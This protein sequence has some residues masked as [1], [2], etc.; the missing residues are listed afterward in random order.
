MDSKPRIMLS[1][2]TWKKF[3]TPASILIPSMLAGILFLGDGCMASR[4]GDYQPPRMGAEYRFEDGLRKEKHP[5][6]LFSKKE[7][8]EMAKMGL[9]VG[10]SNEAV[11]SYTPPSATTK[12][13]DIKP[14]SI[15]ARDTVYKV[16]PQ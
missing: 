11:G 10:A 9:P 15:P 4:G 3:N 1:R 7:R 14:D 16:L 8:K 13:P 6:Y 5:Q 12:S 2:F